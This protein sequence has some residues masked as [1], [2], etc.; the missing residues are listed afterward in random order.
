MGKKRMNL[1]SRSNHQEHASAPTTSK[2]GV[3]SQMMKKQA[4]V[5]ETET[6]KERHRVKGEESRRNRY[7]A[8]YSVRD[9]SVMRIETMRAD[10]K[11]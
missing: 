1:N 2:H 8:R 6:G 11:R 3:G 7:I 10:K 5:S 9:R 4:H